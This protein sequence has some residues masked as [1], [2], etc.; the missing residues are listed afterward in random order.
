MCYGWNTFFFF[1][2][3]FFFRRN[4]RLKNVFFRYLNGVEKMKE[5]I[6]FQMNATI[7]N[8]LMRKNDDHFINDKVLNF[9]FLV[10]LEH[11]HSNYL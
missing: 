9:Q 4:F 7:N 11:E 3:F 10:S 8:I 5:I 6:I 2:K 1:S